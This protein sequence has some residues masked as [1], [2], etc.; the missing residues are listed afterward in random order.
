MNL[1]NR[2]K[3]AWLA[4]WKTN[5]TTKFQLSIS[6]S[7]K[8]DSICASQQLALTQ[9]ISILY[10]P[11]PISVCFLYSYFK[12]NRH[13]VANILTIRIRE[14][15]HLS[16]PIQFFCRANIHTQCPMEFQ[17]EKKTPKT[18]GYFVM[19]RGN[20]QIIPWNNAKCTHSGFES[21]TKHI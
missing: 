16:S 12:E 1:L 8:L 6:I 11:F 7:P 3:H 15:Y 13:F 17:R 9:P 20:N 2:S 21:T 4:W 14:S 5:N 10:F 19:I 18:N